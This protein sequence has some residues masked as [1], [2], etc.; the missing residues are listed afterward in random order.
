[1]VIFAF[2]IVLL[3]F[4]QA[5]EHLLA[6]IKIQVNPNLFLKNPE[7]SKLGRKI[8]QG[9]VELIDEL[10]F[11]DFTFKKLAVKIESTEASIYRYFVSKHK[12]LLY[13]NAWY[14]AWMEYRFVF[15]TANIASP[16]ERLLKALTLLTEKVEVD[17]NIPH[18]NETTLYKIVISEST[19][20]YSTKSVDDDNNLGA[21]L[22]YKQLVQHTCDIVLEIN[23]NYK[24]PHM[25]ITTVIE[26]SH[27]QRFFSEHLPR[28]TDVVKGEDAVV[29]F[30]N[31]LV[32]KAI[33]E[34]K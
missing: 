22:G 33:K 7:S 29:N 5:M 21:Y 24:Y 14:W 10:G 20:A 31:E 25:L 16:E 23:P 3:L 19:K 30:F 6:N 13:L 34:I 11:E 9:G 4:L 8:L 27:H 26:G 32:L 18:I 2:M 12:F 1:M 17:G 15:A 28:L